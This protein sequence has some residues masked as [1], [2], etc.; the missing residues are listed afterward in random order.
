MPTGV[1]IKTE[2]HKKKLSQANKGKPFSVEHCKNISL[3]KTDEKHPMWKGDKVT[4]IPLHI[5][6]SRKLGKP[7]HC[8]ICHNTKLNHRQ[9]NWANISKCYKRELSD[10]IRLCAK[11]HK[12]YDL[13]NIK[14]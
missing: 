6:I 2:E 7:H 8:A 1:Y 4:Y 10:W 5:W 12:N 13:G 9:Y 3:S 11:C 14:L